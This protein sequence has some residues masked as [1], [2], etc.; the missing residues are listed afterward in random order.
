MQSIYNY[1]PESNY[2]CRVIILHHSVVTIYGTRNVTIYGTCNVTIYGTCNVTIYGTYNVTIYGTCNVTI[3][4]TCNV[5]IYGTCNVTIYGT[6]NVTSHEKM[7]C[8]FM[9]R[10]LISLFIA[11]SALYCG[12][13]GW[14]KTITHQKACERKPSCPDL[15]YCVDSFLEVRSKTTSWDRP[16]A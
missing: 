4:G 14:D 8:V 15:R 3:Y 12:F 13:S 9:L 1:I 11:F 16:A 7:F 2:V 5:T 10:L 6:C